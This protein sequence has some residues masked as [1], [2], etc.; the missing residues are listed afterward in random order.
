[1]SGPSFEDLAELI[2]KCQ[3]LKA[4]KP[5][6]PDSQFERDLGVTGD[7]GTELLQKIEQHYGIHF[8][9]ESFQLQD[10]EFLFN[11][12]GL[13]IFG[14]VWRMIRNKP[15]SEVR[16]FTVGELYLALQREIEVKAKRETPQS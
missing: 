1:M 5:I 4:D 3:G 12:E 15:E 14:V 9:P 10:N 7:D 2:R 11:G 13:D 8:T 16:S 6:N